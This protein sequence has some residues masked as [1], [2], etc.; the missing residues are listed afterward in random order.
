MP[1]IF[2]VLRCFSCSTFQVHQVKKSNRYNCK[3]CSVK[4]SVTKVFAQGSGVECRKV[5]Q[6]LNMYQGEKEA[7]IAQSVV[8][9]EAYPEAE[10]AEAAFEQQ[11]SLEH[12]DHPETS[13][14]S[15]WRKY[16]TEESPAQPIEEDNPNFTTSWGEF[17]GCRAKAERN[18]GWRNKP[19]TEQNQKTS[20][21]SLHTK[22]DNTRDSRSQPGTWGEDPVTR[23]NDSGLNHRTR[24][25]E[26]D[27]SRFQSQQKMSV[28]F[29]ASGHSQTKQSGNIQYSPGNGGTVR[30]N[31]GSLS[32]S[33]V[34][35]SF[36]T[37]HF[38]SSKRNCTRAAELVQS[39]LVK[40]KAAVDKKKAT[41]SASVPSS[42]KWSKYA[43]IVE[44]NNSDEEEDIDESGGNDVYLVLKE[45]SKFGNV[46]SSETKS[47]IPSK[48][49]NTSG[50]VG[51]AGGGTSLKITKQDI[52]FSNSIFN[53]MDDD[54]L[55]Q[56]L[57]DNC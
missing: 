20:S 26:M 21:S 8:S 9:C 29:A 57:A 43:D 4:Q 11:D 14:D 52:L 56:I 45:S 6:Q 31:V 40:M 15:K 22:Y 36:S 27:D 12:A 25:A 35:M 49:V 17:A 13:Q 55:D 1:Q 3:M 48:I 38:P 33:S 5:V 37:S 39:S 2:H 54:D 28:N 47:D 7:E 16:D 24:S 50:H 46:S 42:S 51:L 19:Y 53:A 44:E 34:D 18:R 30:K 23:Q 32:S 10:K 41:N